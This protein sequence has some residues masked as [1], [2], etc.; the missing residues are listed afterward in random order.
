[1]IDEA[2]VEKFCT[3][4]RIEETNFDR[5]AFHAAEARNVS[6]EERMLKCY[7][8]GEGKIV[9]LAHGWGSRASH[10]ALLARSLTSGGFRVVTFDGPAHG[11]SRRTDVA[12]TSNMF[13]FGRAV[14]RVAGEYGPIYAVVGHSLGAL[15]AAFAMA[16]TGRLSDY[17]FSAEKLVLISAPEDLS[18]VLENFCRTNGMDSTETLRQSLEGSFGFRV[19]DYSLSGAV[20]ILHAKI[21]VV[22]DE[23]DEEIPSSDALN[24]KKRNEGVEL[25]LTRGFGHGKIL[26]CREMFKAVRDFLLA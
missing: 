6:F 7:S 19:S 20:G 10:M 9:L 25:V 1:M 13:E 16:G 12:D 4:P 15:A 2:L 18:R 11:N 17:R 23:Q 3:P 14:S 21:L 26:I 8:M 22:H 5:R 24:M